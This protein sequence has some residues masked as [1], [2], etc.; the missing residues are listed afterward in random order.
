V[1]VKIRVRTTSKTVVGDEEVQ[2]HD[3]PKA[4]D[5]TCSEGRHPAEYPQNVHPW[6]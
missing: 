6:F 5:L 2:Y 4:P 3:T 1:S